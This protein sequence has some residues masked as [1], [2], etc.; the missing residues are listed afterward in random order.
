MTRPR[1]STDKHIAI[2]PHGY[3]ASIRIR[4]QL[5]QQRF[6]RTV[7]LVK[8]KQWLLHVEMK[9]RRGGPTSGRFDDDAARYLEGVRAMPTYA[10]RVLQINEWVAVFGDRPRDEITSG[11]IAA[12]L[13]RWRTETRL[14][15]KRAKPGAEASTVPLVL[16][17][18]SV[19][20]RRTAL[21]HMYRTLDGKSERNPVKDTPKFSEPTPAPR[22]IPFSK[23]KTLFQAMPASKSRAR[24]MVMAYTGIPHAQLRTITEE[25]VNFAGKT[26]A[27]AGR[28]KGKGTTGRIM[29]L[30]P[31]A[32][33]AFQAMR[34]ESA[35]GG[36][37][38][39]TLRQA[40]L[41]GC[42]AARIGEGFRPYDLRHS[43]ATEVFRR[44]GDIRA[45]QLLLDHSTLSLTHRYTLGASDARVAAAIAL[46]SRAKGASVVPSSKKR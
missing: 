20:K 41:R 9:Y 10:Q 23:L 8:I 39:A 6:K 26:V 3:R 22:G 33:R 7:P 40:F 15:K 31:E 18:S 27:V 36:F 14:V 21:M 24:L 37:S 42:K 34:R 35:W 2:T 12:Q 32:V 29:P 44:S 1:R 30:I 43:F 4:G 16:S 25:A 5:H 19:N 11:E 46:F 38:R 28:R 45:V 13:H 17:A